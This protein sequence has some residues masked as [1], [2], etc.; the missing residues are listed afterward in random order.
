MKYLANIK[1]MNERMN[2]LYAEAQ[3]GEIISFPQNV[4]IVST[5]RCNYRCKVCFQTDFNGELNWKVMDNIEPILPFVQ[6]LHPFGGEP[7]LYKRIGDF[8]NLAHEYDCRVKIITNGALIDADMA[9]NL[10]AKKIHRLLVSIDAGTAATYKHLRGGDFDQLLHN[11]E[12]IAKEKRLQNS[13]VPHLEFNVLAMKSN[14]T[15]LPGLVETA[16]RLGVETINVFYPKILK[17]ELIGECLWFSQ[18]LSDDMMLAA[19]AK[20][21]E[22]GVAVVPTSLFAED[23]KQMQGA[24]FRSAQKC[25]RPWRNLNIDI[26]GNATLC[27]FGAPVIGNVQS[28]D[29][30]TVWNSELA[31]KIRETVG[32]D[33]EYDFCRTCTVRPYSPKNIE[34]HMP[35]DIHR[36][37]PK[38]LLAA[39][40][41]R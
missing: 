12:A 26:F 6:D 17:E 41:A 3:T 20:G 16:A 8:F 25:T 5:F 18:N 27:C 2:D 28:Q 1:M 19:I 36:K 39:S 23:N 29:F 40:Q 33:Q 31:R 24:V 7:F 21:R 32:T 4:S 10:V 34:Y 30:N 11:L 37:I 22:E 9:W 14:I 13:L 35:P 15:E 38:D